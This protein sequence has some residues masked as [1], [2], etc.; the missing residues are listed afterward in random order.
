MSVSIPAQTTCSHCAA[1]RS[2]SCGALTTTDCCQHFQHGPNKA[3]PCRAPQEIFKEV[4]TDVSAGETWCQLIGLVILLITT[5]VPVI[6]L[7]GAHRLKPGEPLLPLFLAIS[8]V[9]GAI[10]MSQCYP[11]RGY[12]LPGIIAGPLFGPGVFL[13]FWFLAPV[14]LNKLIFLFLVVLGGAPSFCL[15]LLLLWWKACLF[16]ARS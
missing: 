7:W 10:G 13:V 8:I 4:W 1:I 9:G 2:A 6:V 15:Y 3:A 5:F 14:V 12:W 11:K 16:E